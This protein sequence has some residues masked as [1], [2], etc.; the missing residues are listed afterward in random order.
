MRKKRAK[1]FNTLSSKA[2]ADQ[3]VL[4]VLFNGY[5]TF[6]PMKYWARVP[7]S[8]S[9][10]GQYHRFSR[11]ALSN[12][13]QDT[14]SLCLCLSIAVNQCSTSSTTGNWKKAV[15]S[16]EKTQSCLLPN[17]YIYIYV[18]VYSMRACVCVHVLYVHMYICICLLPCLPDCLP[19]GP[20]RTVILSDIRAKLDLIRTK[21]AVIPSTSLWLLPY[22]SPPR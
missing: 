3:R 14:L 21:V 2:S 8:Q 19:C 15:T 6:L 18:Y 9:K 13:R 17:A 22:G 16:E 11:S 4:V 12:F 20:P 5:V 7:C 1:G 10:A